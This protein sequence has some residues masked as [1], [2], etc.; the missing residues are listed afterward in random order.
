MMMFEDVVTT[1]ITQT[2]TVSVTLWHPISFKMCHDMMSQCVLS[3]NSWPL[4]TGQKCSVL[5]GDDV[6]ESRTHGVMWMSGTR[7]AECSSAAH[8]CGASSRV[9][10]ATC[11]SPDINVLCCSGRVELT[12]FK[13]KLEAMQIFVPPPV[14]A[15]NNMY[16]NESRYC[17][18]ALMSRIFGLNWTN[19]HRRDHRSSVLTGSSDSTWLGWHS[20]YSPIIHWPGI[21][22]NLSWH[23]VIET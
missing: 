18:C 12:P 16:K 15:M 1:L 2:G 19:F 13:V 3:A 14:C 23:L 8:L 4:D 20:H 9:T 11:L 21:L 5:R 17:T 7:G 22:V 6:F 10:P